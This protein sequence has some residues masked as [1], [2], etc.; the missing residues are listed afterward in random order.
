MGLN[1]LNL[2]SKKLN[3]ENLEGVAGGVISK[4]EDAYLK[5]I[6]HIYKMGGK[7]RE[8]SLEHLADVFTNCSDPSKYPE[9]EELVAWFD[10]NWDSL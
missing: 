10:D 3:A 5:Q 8:A 2:N 7:S 6:C 4:Q 1:E 9:Y